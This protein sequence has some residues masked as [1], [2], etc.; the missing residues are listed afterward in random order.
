M[1]SKLAL[2]ITKWLL[3]LSIN[4]KSMIIPVL[5]SRPKKTGILGTPPCSRSTT[6]NVRS[7]SALARSH[8]FGSTRLRTLSSTSKMN[9]LSFATKILKTS[10]TGETMTRSARTS[11]FLEAASS[12]VAEENNSRMKTRRSKRTAWTNFSSLMACCRTFFSPPKSSPTMWRG[13]VSSLKVTSLSR[14]R[15][16]FSR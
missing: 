6:A 11:I 9:F 7:S 14:L 2:S 15:V 16:R 1:Y 13:P 10:L 5:T 3:S 8:M 4:A 12:V